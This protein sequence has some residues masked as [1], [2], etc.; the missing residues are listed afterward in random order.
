MKREFSEA[1]LLGRLS[2]P[3]RDRSVVIEFEIEADVRSIADV[4]IEKAIL[5]AIR[6][7]LIDTVKTTGFLLIKVFCKSYKA[8]KSLITS[9]FLRTET[10]T[11]APSFIT[12]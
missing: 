12:R 9:G 4:E 2:I 5:Y 1:N 7:V 11:L 8:F 3:L 6:C 10:G